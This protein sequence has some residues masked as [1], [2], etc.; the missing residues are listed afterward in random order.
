MMPDT[1][2]R[3]CEHCNQTNWFPCSGQGEDTVQ[4]PE[5]GKDFIAKYWTTFDVM[6]WMVGG[7]LGFAVQGW[8]FIRFVIFLLLAD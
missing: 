2:V 8:L 1:L 6:F 7:S 3:T 4:C 5:C